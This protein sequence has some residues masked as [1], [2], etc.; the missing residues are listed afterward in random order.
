MQRSPG[1]LRAGGDAGGGAAGEQP[2]PEPRPQAEPAR[3]HAA[4]PVGTKAPARRCHT[5]LSP[6]SRPGGA[7]GP[8][9][10]MEAKELQERL[11]EAAALGDAEEVRRLLAA[12][13]DVNSRNEIDGW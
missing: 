3:L 9:A 1:A 2:E 13:A 4:L 10:G 6:P 12:G 8:A 7:P 11:R 5:E